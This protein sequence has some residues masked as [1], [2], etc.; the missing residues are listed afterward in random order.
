MNKL[1]LATLVALLAGAATGADLINVPEHGLRIP[2]GFTIT[3]VADNDLVPDTWCMTFDAR[4]RLVVANSQ[5]IRILDDTDNDGVFDASDVFAPVKRGVM[6]MAFD[7]HTLHA[8]ADDAL[9]RFE[10]GDGNSEADGPPQKLFP[11]GFGEHG[12]HAIRKGPDG[13][14][15]LIGG[16]DTSFNQRHVTLA[17]SPVAKPEAGALLRLT[18]DLSGSECIAHGFRNP[19]S[20]DFNPLGDIFTYDSDTERDIFLPWHEPTRVYHVGHAQHHGWRL[21]GYKRSF[22]RP[23]YYADVTPPLVRVGRGSPTGVVC[24]RHTAFPQAYR[25]GVFHADWTFGR[26]YFTPLDL[27]GASYEHTEPEVFIEPLGTQGFAPTDLAVSP[28]GALHISIGGRKTRGAVYRIDY[29]GP[30]SPRQHLPLANADLNN[31]LSAPQPLDAWSRAIWVPLAQRLGAPAFAA[32]ASEESIAAPLRVRA[33]EVLTELFGGMPPGRVTYMTQSREPAVRARLAWSLGRAPLEISG[34]A[35]AALAN[36]NQPFVRRCALEALIDRPSLAAPEVLAQVAAANLAHTD[37]RVRLAATRLAARA[38]DD[39]W[40]A[41]TNTLS[42]SAALAQAGGVLAEMWRAP[43]TL[44]FPQLVPRL[45]NILALARDPVSRLDV[46][47]LLILAHGDWHLNDPS[48]EV[49]A[50][51]E[52]A[53]AP[54][55]AVESASVARQL[56]AVFPSGSTNLDLEIGRLLA[57]LADDDRRS[58]GVMMALVTETSAAQSDFHYLACLARLRAPLAEHAPRIAHA[59]LNLNRKLDGQ[60]QR[61]KQS[62]DARLIELVQHYT[63]REP[64]IADA[65]LQHPR[66]V[67]PA[68]LGLA[69]TL[70]GEQ[71]PAAARRF[72]AAARDPRFP[73]SG[74]LV[75]FIGELPRDEVLPLFRVRAGNPAAREAILVK[76]AAAPQPSDRGLFLGGL[77]SPQAPVARASLEALLKL[78]PD[79]SGTNLVAPLRLLRRTVGE[80]AEAAMRAQVVALLAASLK[81]EFNIQEA[82]GAKADALRALYQPVFDSLTKKYPGLARALNADD[83]DDTTRFASFTRGAPWNAGDAGR[84]EQIYNERACAACHSSSSA[85]GPDLAGA[86]QRMSREDLMAAIVFP[87]RDVAPAY[88]TTQFHLRDGQTVMGLIAFESADGWIVQ[89]GAGAT[90]RVNSADVVSRDASSVSV[91]PSGLLGGLSPAAWADLHAYL[92]TLQTR[93]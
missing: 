38:P 39:A 8:V 85:I 4:G 37:E 65:L 9:C 76:L 61:V 55:N 6:G 92:K 77:G 25:G 47:R 17:G 91:M 86:A 34:S 74:A 87:S 31:V 40:H 58:A 44:A 68:H 13:S 36:D 70:S 93:R 73:W 29:D 69:G 52:P 5:S 23:G 43:D 75:D 80:P 48:V 26:V 10:D 50:P 60:E 12:A 45:T 62:W 53:V 59:I 88:R 15:Y 79:P 51:Y 1:F 78:P 83:A 57:M 19:Y 3:Q 72:L 56:R 71:R 18:P 64:K 32:I 81:Q 22:P 41:L 67:A 33:I 82:P 49:L 24:Y 28:D 90:A 63:R 84:G 27:D 2:R 89:T 21:T 46:V 54:A 66:L 42:R 35:L 14:W 20:F 7:G 16:N 11:F 30:P